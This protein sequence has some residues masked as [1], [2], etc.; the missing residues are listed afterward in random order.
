[1]VRFK[2]FD[3]STVEEA[4]ELLYRF[5][6]KAKVIAGG[7]D[8]VGFYK[9]NILPTPYEALI[10]IK[11]IPGLEEIKEEDG[12]L[13]IGT[14]VRLEDIAHNTA[15]QENYTALALA[16]RHAASPHIREMGTIGGNVCQNSRCWYFRTPNNR[17]SCARKG[18]DE[19]FASEGDNRYHSIFGDVKDC[20]AVNPSDTL[21]ALI[22]LGTK[23]VTSKRTLD[24]TEMFPEKD[25]TRMHI[26]DPDEIIT[27]FQIPAPAA[28]MKSSWKKFAI[29][30][31][32]D[33]PIVN[34]A[35][36]VTIADGK[37]ED[38]MLCLNAVYY[39]PY[40]P[41]RAVAYLKGKVL[42]EEVAET[43]GEAAVWGAKPLAMNEY[44]IQI[45]KGLI[46]QT[47]L[48]CR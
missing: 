6:G 29:R 15:I 35:A 28:G 30:K 44:K 45:A 32:I 42:D 26:L 48:A 11:T 19:C 3:A 36:A 2:H 31:S 40:V 17:F 34:C 8:I 43:T 33:F 21:P 25:P 18:G 4:V 20:L 47:L 7:T 41:A 27:E 38:A 23:I 9:D 16:A 5:E 46:K 10:N 12:F 39:K 13:R 37:V 1:M 14:L 24:I 22:A